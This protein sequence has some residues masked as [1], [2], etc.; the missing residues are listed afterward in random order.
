MSRNDMLSYQT[1]RKVALE[2]VQLGRDVPEEEWFED[3]EHYATS[4][5][6][7]LVEE[8]YDEGRRARLGIR[9][10]HASLGK[11]LALQSVDGCPESADRLPLHVLYG[12]RGQNCTEKLIAAAVGMPVNESP[13]LVGIG[14]EKRGPTVDALQDKENRP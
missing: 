1:M 10:V 7:R 5:I 6:R 8:A 14:Q 11:K 3:A 4:L 2:I 13:L 9:L 12:L